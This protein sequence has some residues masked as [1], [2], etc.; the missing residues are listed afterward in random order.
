M[1][2]I[3]LCSEGASF[4]ENFT[5][6]ELYRYLYLLSGELPILSNA[7]IA[8]LKK[9]NTPLLAVGSANS[10]LIEKFVDEKL[11]QVSTDDPG[12]DG[13]ILKSFKYKSRDVLAVA[14]SSN[15]GTLYGAY[16]LLEEYG[17]GFYL[18]GDVIPDKKISLK[19]LEIDER[20]KPLFRLR[21]IL[22]FHDFPEGP[23]WWNTDDY[24]AYISQLPKLGMNFIG[25]HTYP[26]G[27]PNA[28]PTV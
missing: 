2:L 17:L 6:R 12:S 25:L 11:I 15:I 7:G 5:V 22:P 9:G 13:Y 8:E 27:G 1:S 4:L 26:E 18:H 14:G 28:E 21:G 10:E 3:I 23:D 20:K 24:K 16:A 19:L